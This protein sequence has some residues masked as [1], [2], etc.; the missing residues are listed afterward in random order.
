MKRT[1][2]GKM[3]GVAERKKECRERQRERDE[4]RERARASEKGLGRVAEIDV[5]RARAVWCSYIQ[6]M[7]SIPKL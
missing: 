2:E 7:S 3:K 6:K 4:E 1:A 5:D